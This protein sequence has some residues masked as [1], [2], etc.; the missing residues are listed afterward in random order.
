MWLHGGRAVKKEHSQGVEQRRLICT[1]IAACFTVVYQFTGY[2]LEQQLR[3]RAR[4][5]VQSLDTR[6]ETQLCARGLVRC[7]PGDSR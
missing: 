5:E 2:A 6:H 4:L 1:D 7:V 3:N